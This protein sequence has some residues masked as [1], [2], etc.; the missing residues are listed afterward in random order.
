M[1]A[2]ENQCTGCADL[3]LPCL[4]RS[5]PNRKVQVFYCDNKNCVAS[6]TGT[7][8]LFKVGDSQICMDCVYEIADRNG[9]EPEDLIE[10]EV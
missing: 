3:G 8:R 9:V 10:G 7:D 1:I 6:F 2:Y 4:G 5:C